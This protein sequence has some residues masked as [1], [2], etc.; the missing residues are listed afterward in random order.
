MAADGI[1]TDLK[2]FEQLPTETQRVVLFKAV[3]DLGNKFD[4][5][6]PDCRKRFRELER[7]KKWNMA[8]SGGGGIVGGFLAVLG[9]VLF[10]K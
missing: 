1:K 9:K 3:V 5:R 8:A 7:Q 6:V 10:W 2:E 4:E